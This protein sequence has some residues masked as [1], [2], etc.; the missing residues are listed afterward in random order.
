MQQIV[1]DFDGPL[2]DGR[3]AAQSALEQTFNQFESRFGRPQLSFA[4]VPL[5]G[6]RTLVSMFYHDLER[7]AREE[8][9]IY[10]QTK[11]HA[12]ERLLGVEPSVHSTL[13][14]LRQLGCPLAVFSARKEDELRSLMDHLGLLRG[15]RYFT[16][17]CELSG[18]IVPSSKVIFELESYLR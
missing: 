18:L 15:R 5:F 2:F 7:S 16:T 13:Q 8:I 6:P 1:F 10:Y 11:L 17:C 4:T 12:A 14:K 9:R 3:K